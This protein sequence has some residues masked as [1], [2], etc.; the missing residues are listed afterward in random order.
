[1]PRPGRLA[2]SGKSVSGWLSG[3]RDGLGRVDLVR[4]VERHLGLNVDT[5]LAHGRPEAIVAKRVECR[6][7]LP[8]VDV[9]AVVSLPP[10]DVRVAA[11]GWTL[12]PANLGSDTVILLGRDP[13][14]QNVSY[15][16]H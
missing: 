12:E 4:R 11:V 10:C 9:V 15:N 13:S 7:A 6:F 16:G 14:E 5:E 3:Q 2:Y 1:M 8:G